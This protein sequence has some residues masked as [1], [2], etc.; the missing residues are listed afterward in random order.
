MVLGYC[1]QFWVIQKA[2]F[3][4]TKRQIPHTCW[5]S[6]L[7]SRVTWLTHFFTFYHILLKSGPP[8]VMWCPTSL[9][10]VF[11]IYIDACS[12]LYFVLTLKHSLWNY[13]SSD[14]FLIYYLSIY[15]C[16]ACQTER[17]T[18]VRSPLLCGFVTKCHIWCRKDRHWCIS[19]ICMFLPLVSQLRPS[20]V[21][22]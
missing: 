8:K 2:K 7:Y 19:S 5:G 3:L 6:T 20:T 4:P 11:A 18:F 13:R 22:T 21:G 15:S 14:D 1:R 17:L 9:L 10:C 16:D 12:V